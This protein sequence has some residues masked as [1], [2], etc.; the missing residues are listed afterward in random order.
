[1]DTLFQ[2]LPHVQEIELLTERT[3][4]VPKALYNADNERAL[5]AAAGLTPLASECV[6]STRTESGITALMAID[7]E[8]L[9]RLKEEHGDNLNF[10]TPLLEA[11]NVTEPTVW[12]VEC[13]YLIYIKVY[14]LALT[15]AEVVRLQ[16]DEELDML[17]HRLTTQGNLSGY[18][19]R[20]KQRNKNKQRLHIY[21]N[22]FKQIVCE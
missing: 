3:L 16:T 11:P 14:G 6:V 21:R 2:P 1:M 9:K 22:H 4:L 18:T 8:E 10:T 12:I 17:L 7:S 5:L 20:L 15:M 13:G 19:L